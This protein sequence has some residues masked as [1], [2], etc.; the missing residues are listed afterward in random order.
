MSIKHS[1]YAR[2]I[3]CALCVAAFTRCSSD[4]PTDVDHHAG[5]RDFRQDMRTFVQNISAYARA[6]DTDFI[7]IP[8]NG[9]EIL[10]T[11]GE[12]NGTPATNYINAINGVGR[13]DLLYGYSTDDQ[14]TP[15]EETAYML[16]FLD[17]AK[18]HGIRV[19]TTD[20][21]WTHTKMDDSYSKNAARGYISFAA[22]KR[23]LDRIPSYP[24]TPYNVNAS[25][26][27]TL[28]EA[29]NFLYL[30]DPS[31]Q[32][33]DKAAF[34]NALK[35]TNYDVLII[36]LFPL[37]TQLTAADLAALKVKANGGRRLVICYMSVGEAEDY[38]YYWQ[39]GWKPGNPSWLDKENPDWE[40][41]Y[42]VHY[43]DAGWQA[44][45]YGNADSYCRKI[46]DAGFDGAY[47]D[48]IDAFEYYEQ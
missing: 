37:E 23:E 21:C 25:D 33:A 28:A 7:L 11:D 35:A 39:S 42:K 8:Q 9:Q 16:E 36:D 22:E 45:I 4:K 2:V 6:I 10:T 44:I 48:I 12:S 46:L 24:A 1:L 5:D 15:A 17:F 3:A 19:L 40:G 14:A 47:L 43:W 13:E 31:G 30:L 32:Y 41:N 29:K 26:I 38:R 20:Y 27:T 18:N 34:V